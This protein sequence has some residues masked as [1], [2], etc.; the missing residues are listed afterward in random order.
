MDTLF[1]TLA[2]VD[3]HQEVYRNIV[4][5]RVSEDLFDDLTHD[6]AEWALA[7]QVEQ[8]TKPPPYVS[9]AP[10][11][12]RPFEDGAWFNAIAWPF[13]HWQAS[14]FSDGSFGVWYGADAIE[15]TAFESAYHWYHGLLADAG[16]QDAPVV[17]ERKLY[18]VR[19]DA[20]MLDFRGSTPEHAALRH[21][22]DYSLAQT[23]GAR[24]HREGHPGLLFQSVRR[25]AGENVAV[26]NP[27]V[28][29]RPRHQC[30]LTYRLAG[31]AIQ[32][33][34]DPGVTWFR[35]DLAHIR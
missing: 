2:I 6:P 35:I 19:C 18:L 1:N 31:S 26:F 13:K 25:P 33:E 17:A 11:I 32:V 7:Q 12:D 15:T 10:V 14:R 9:H 16:F 5:L 30:Y 23:V 20:A 8:Q 4:S 22:T 27:T 24:L 34:K 3:F 21:P 28:L 29:S